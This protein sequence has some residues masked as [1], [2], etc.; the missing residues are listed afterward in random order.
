MLAGWSGEAVHAGR[1]VLV[2]GEAGV[3]K[4][5]V[6]NEF[7]AELSS[8]TPVLRGWCESLST[9]RPLAA[10]LDVAAQTG[11]PL[12]AAVQ[13]DP[14]PPDVIG[15]LLTTLA[16]WPGTVL[17]I[18]DLH[19]A[20]DATLDLVRLISRRVGDVPA[21]VVVT[22]RDDELGAV[23]PLRMLL[24]DLGTRPAVRR[25][26]LAPLTEAAVA[27]LATGTD[28]DAGELF[29]LTGGNPFYV[30]EVLNAGAAGVPVTVR[31]AVLA[32]VARLS[33][34]ARR[35]LEAAATIGTPLDL[36]LLRAVA[37]TDAA[38]L[39]E[40][41]EAGV[42]RADGDRVAF[43]HE[44]ARRAV[45]EAMAPARRALLHAEI[46]GRLAG[47]SDVPAAR[48][49]HHAAAAG[50][51]DAVGRYAEQA[52]RHAA[53]LGA[54]REAA[55][56]YRRV[57]AVLDPAGTPER[58]RLLLSLSLECSLSDQLSEATASAEEALRI[59]Q[60]AGDR[61]REGDTV[62]CLAR[63]A[64]MSE[65]GRDALRLSH[66]AVEVLEPLSAGVELAGAYAQCARVG[67]N[68]NLIAD[69]ATWAQR[70]L[71][72]C[73][74]L[75]EP[76]IAAEAA[77]DL[78][79]ARALRDET[80]QGAVALIEAGATRAHDLGLDE[81]AARGLFALGRVAWQHRHLPEADQRFRAAEQYCH[82]RGV[83]FFEDYSLAFHAA[84]LLDLGD[85]SQAEALAMQVWQRTVPSSSGNRTAMVC[86]VLGRLNTWRGTTDSTDYFASGK[87]VD[88][89]GFISGWGLGV[90]A[91]R[92]E[93]A[94]LNGRLSDEI[95]PLLEAAER[96]RADEVARWQQAE[97][98]WWLRAAGVE[99]EIE[100]AGP[101]AAQAAGDWRAA[102]DGWQALGMPYHRA[103]ALAQADEEPALREGLD[104][105]RDLGAVP[106][107]RR[108]AQRLRAMGVRDLPRLAGSSAPGTPGLI[109]PREHEVLVLLADG[110]RDADIAER[111]TIS[112]RT[113]HH[114]VASLRAKLDAPSRTGAVAEATRQGLLTTED[115]D[116]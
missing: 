84:V 12:A 64:W 57:L 16:R 5:T 4:T 103:V 92:A 49:A 85:W 33:A 93:E 3:G 11:G 101:F 37:G 14:R 63:L 47:E 69:A 80:D 88:R 94:W 51:Q 81:H 48:L 107:A 83:E 36:G 43:R 105:C 27:E 112:L 22:Y 74:R 31:D 97:V 7:L 104:M 116:T 100:G 96:L 71:D 41:A 2:A 106:L 21:L 26:S 18:E 114:H 53:R 59:W 6:V 54:H 65:R 70:A 15:V 1:M 62:R 79:L 75:G 45:E 46:L 73:D 52:A 95:D 60:A 55:A 67:N 56:Q 23:H 42:L 113:V 24:G 87:A 35:A 39:D 99:V 8:R 10:L 109:T 20:D 115:G 77:I 38:G 86:A 17:V 98:C 72:L 29:R 111:L 102:A 91:G 25:L 13:A 90:V 32:R 68:L 40:C 58:A 50:D 61:Q 110:L 78:G 28:V 82:G 44:L 19:W 30:T 34:S 66:R 89:G 9:P 108:I 76:G